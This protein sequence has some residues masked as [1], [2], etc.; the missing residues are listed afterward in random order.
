[1]NAD[2]TRGFDL[3]RV[4]PCSSVAGKSCSGES[5]QMPQV[6][7]IR[8]HKLRDYRL[9]GWAERIVGRWSYRQLAADP[10]WK[11]GWISLDVAPCPPAGGSAAGVVSLTGG[12]PPRQ[13]G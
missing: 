10:D 11:A 2:R 7:D 6:K 3:I 9:S 8:A 13:R 4:H 5:G 1:M 12:K